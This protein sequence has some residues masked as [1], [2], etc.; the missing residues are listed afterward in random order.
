MKMCCRCTEIKHSDEFGKGRAV[1][2]LCYSK[3]VRDISVIRVTVLGCIALLCH[4]LCHPVSQRC[5][6]LTPISLHKS[7]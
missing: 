1:C 2:R 5:H 6:N 7:Q 3:Q 4:G